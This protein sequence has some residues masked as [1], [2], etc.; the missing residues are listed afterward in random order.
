ME[1]FIPV[2]ICLSRLLCIS[3]KIWALCASQLTQ[4]YVHVRCY[5]IFW[6][7]ETARYILACREAS[8]SR[9][10]EKLAW[11]L[12]KRTKCHLVLNLQE[13]LCTLRHKL[14]WLLLTRPDLCSAA[15]IASQ[16]N[17]NEFNSN[18][19]RLMNKLVNHISETAGRNQRYHSLY[20]DFLHWEAMSVVSFANKEDLSLQ[21]EQNIILMD[22]SKS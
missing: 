11:N 9:P 21:L 16:S 2:I 4:I 13:S 17:M 15:N 3:R 22:K 7:A 8:F 1:I 6:S 20:C 18:H 14:V 5:K 19:V 10:T 12:R